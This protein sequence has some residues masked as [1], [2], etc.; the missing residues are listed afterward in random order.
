M[1]RLL[2]LCVGLAAFMAFAW[3]GTTVPLGQHTLFGH[4][5][6]IAGTKES[7]ELVDGTKEAAEPLVDGVRKRIASGGDKAGGKAGGKDGEKAGDR[8][9]SAEKDDGKATASGGEKSAASPGAKPTGQ[10]QETVT[11]DDKQRLKR[12]IGKSDQVR[13]QR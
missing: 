6:N 5:H 1:I 2:K 9:E 3:F 7:K 10:P 4:L 11:A 12:L 8:G 13:V